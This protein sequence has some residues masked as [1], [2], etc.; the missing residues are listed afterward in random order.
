M[1]APQSIPSPQLIF[2]TLGGHQRA[3]ALK[4]A[5][6]LDVFSAIGKD[7]ATASSIAKKTSAH[8]RG[9]RILCDGLV[10]YGLLIKEDQRYGLTAESAFF[11]DRGSPAYIGSI[12][13]FLNSDVLLQA[14]AKLTDSVRKGG[15]ALERDST[16]DENPMWVNFAR[17]MAPM[18]MMPAQAIARIVG[19]GAA[20]MKVLDVA[21]GHG[22]FGLSVA[23]RNP[24][25]QVTAQDWASVLQVAQENAHRFGLEDRFRKLEGNAFSVDFGAGYDLVLFTNFLHH[26]D[27]ATCEQLARKAYAALKPGGQLGIVEFVPNDDRVSPPPA[28]TFALTMLAMTPAGDAYTYAQLERICANAGFTKLERHALHPTPQAFLLATK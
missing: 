20:P 21:A 19:S 9:I 7:G 11:L 15:T 28:A 25:A 8:E 24:A 18:V 13:T 17:S 26:F 10:A 27:A 14:W 12:A 22:L 4:A 3:A 2:D 5:I 6:D 1:S 16:A 23:R